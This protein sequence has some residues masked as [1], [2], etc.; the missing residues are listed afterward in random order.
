METVP[1]SVTCCPGGPVRA[2]TSNWDWYC[3]WCATEGYDA[4]GAF[5]SDAMPFQP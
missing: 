3:V 2:W 4:R 5:G 1:T